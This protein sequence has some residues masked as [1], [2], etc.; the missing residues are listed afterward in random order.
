ME[1]IQEAESQLKYKMNSVAPVSNTRFVKVLAVV[2]PPS[3]QQ[4]ALLESERVEQ[5]QTMD[6]LRSAERE[7]KHSLTQVNDMSVEAQKNK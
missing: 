3:A 4:S 6:S 7:L 1:S 2:E 5:A